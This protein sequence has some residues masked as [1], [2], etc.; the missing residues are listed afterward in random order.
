MRI[1]L[2]EKQLEG[3]PLRIGL[4]MRTG[5]DTHDRSGD[6]LTKVS[7]SQAAYSTPI[8][9]DEWSSANELMQSLVS[10]NLQ[11]LSSLADPPLGAQKTPMSNTPAAVGLP[12]KAKLTQNTL[13]ALL[14]AGLFTLPTL[15]QA[16]P[17][18]HYV[19][20]TEGLKGASLPVPGFY[21]RDY[22]VAY[23]AD[24]RRD[25]HGNEISALDAK[26][27]IYANVPRFIWITDQ[28]ILGGYL[29]FDALLP[30]GYTH[31]DIKANGGPTVIDH[32][33]FGL[34][35]LF[36]EVTWSKHIA[37]FDFGLGYGVYAPTGDS[38]G[39]PPQF[40]STMPGLGYWTH[41]LTAGATWYIDADKKWALSVLNRYEINQHKDDSG[42][43]PGQAYT[44]EWGASRALS[45]TLDAGVTGY[46]QQKVTKDSG[47]GASSVRDRVA[48]IGPEVSA[49]F[50]GIT[51]GV[52]LRYEYEF[53]AESR[54]KGQTFVLTV[55]K[56]F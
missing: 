38:S 20:G 2:E 48:G 6:K 27:F 54:S 1:V 11:A 37:R 32:S 47:S 12:I 21:L 8:Y 14:A 56:R 30:L 35:D 26:A 50:P 16:Q 44:L 33:T 43:T 41:M 4:S 24:T 55:T 7:T 18:A 42:I 3:F 39:K 36:G 5:I 17:T 13:G 40:P 25:A 10:T 23:Y 29:G 19:P 53:M 28:Q 22:N 49:F 15:M 52:S 51:L 34:G 45:P 31:L 46:Y 9:S